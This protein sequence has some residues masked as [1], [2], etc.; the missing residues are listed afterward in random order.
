MSGIASINS[1]ACANSVGG[2][3]SMPNALAVRCPTAEFALLDVKGQGS[4]QKD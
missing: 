3:T 4:L 2:G 1:S